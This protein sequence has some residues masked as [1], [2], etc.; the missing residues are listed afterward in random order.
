MM[1][2]NFSYIQT[3]SDLSQALNSLRGANRLALDTETYTLP[4]WEKKLGQEGRL[5][6]H[7]GRISLLQ[8]KRDRQPTCVFDLVCL[9]AAGVDLTPLVELLQSTPKLVAHNALFECKMIRGHFGT[10]LRN[11]NCTMLMGQLLSNATG[12][13]FGKNK[14]H[15]LAALCRDYLS[16]EMTGKGSLQIQQ[17]YTDPSSRRL[18][19]PVWAAMLT[20]A[21]NDVEYLFP[22]Y[23]FLYPVLTNP[24][25]QSP[26]TQTG[27]EE[28][29]GFGMSTIL[30]VEFGAIALSAEMEFNGLPASRSLL[31]RIQNACHQE[32]QEPARRVVEQFGLEL[33]PNP[34]FFAETA[35][36]PH[37]N[38]L[39]VLNNPSKVKEQVNKLLGTELDS[40]QTKLF[41]R[42]IDVLEAYGKSE[43]IE[44]AGEDEESLYKELELLDEAILLHGAEV[45]QNFL[46][47]KKLSKQV[48]AD[49][50]PY[51][52]PLTGCIHAGYSQLG[53][54][55]GRYAS[56]QPNAQQISAR[57]E[58]WV[59]VEVDDE[60]GE[61]EFYMG[62]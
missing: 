38:S 44:L 21:A 39:K 46:R 49:L 58:V 25:P 10:L 48:S 19:N 53:A 26:V 35:Y 32:S 29:F 20:Y 37:P 24:L 47:Y 54:S 56:R 7:T 51:I 14:G 28:N 61:T 18:D 34:D 50:R 43:Q 41:E 40:A 52:N 22:I 23:D 62:S 60:T 12:S 6:P 59:E 30:A 17:W 33:M 31:G 3:E 42:T 5:S 1:A 15:S 27:V 13:K 45:L 57:L 16:I 4:E 8:L 55:T 9:E 2:H 36:V 11:L